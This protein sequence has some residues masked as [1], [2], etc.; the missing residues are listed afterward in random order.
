MT[1][2]KTEFIITQ[3]GPIELTENLNDD[4]A[5]KIPIQIQSDDTKFATAVAFIKEIYYHASVGWVPVI[6][7]EEIGVDKVA[8]MQTHQARL[9]MA[10]Q[11]FGNYAFGELFRLG[12][13]M[14]DLIEQSSPAKFE[15]EVLPTWGLNA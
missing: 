12:E 1:K 15:S 6:D 7:G 11:R 3:T 8:I 2:K 9:E 13:K 10:I 5:F 4:P 14:W